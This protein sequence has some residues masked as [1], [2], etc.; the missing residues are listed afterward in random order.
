VIFPKEKPP[1]ILSRP[2][3]PRITTFSS[4]EGDVACTSAHSGGAPPSEE[5]NKS[6]G[7]DDGCFS[8]VL[9]G[10]MRRMEHPPTFV[11]GFRNFS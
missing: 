11:F 2:S 10:Q 6:S 5:A 9:A 7:D 3:V 4:S 1:E 8:Q